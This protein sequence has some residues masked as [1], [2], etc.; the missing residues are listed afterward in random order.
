[1]KDRNFFV[2]AV[3]IAVG[4]PVIL[5]CVYLFYMEREYGSNEMIAKLADKREMV[6]LGDTQISSRFED[7][8]FVDFEVDYASGVEP[9]TL[10]DLVVKDLNLSRGVDGRDFSWRLERFSEGSGTYGYVASGNFKGIEETVS[11]G[12]YHIAITDA[13]RYRLYYQA[14]EKVKDKKLFARIAVE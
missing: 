7:K 9:V 10:Y 11:L 13:H 5:G 12:K 2:L 4:V 1:M 14:N 8:E 6:L 3:V